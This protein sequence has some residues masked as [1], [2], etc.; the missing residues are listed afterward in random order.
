MTDQMISVA[1][2]QEDDIEL[3]FFDDFGGDPGENDF[4]GD[5][6]EF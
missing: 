5:P 4:G 2:V 1:L 6:A 3:A